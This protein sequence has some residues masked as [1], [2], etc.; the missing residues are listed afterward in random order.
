MSESTSSKG[1]V[2]VVICNP[3]GDA[4]FLGLHDEEKDIKYIP[5]FDSKDDA[6]DCF[7]SLPREKGIKYE[8][9]AVHLDELTDDAQENGFEIA[10]LNGDG[11]VV[12]KD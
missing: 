2:Y 11:K 9:Q 6:N 4:S 8:I 12:K 5:A 7:L 10:F 3:E 1:W